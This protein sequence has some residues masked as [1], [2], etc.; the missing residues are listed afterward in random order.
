M[1]NITQININN[2][3]YFFNDIISIRNFYSKLLK[4]N[5]KLY[6]N[7]DIYY[8]RYVAMRNI[9]DY[10]NIHSVNPLYFLSLVK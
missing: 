6:K 3:T 8:I 2:L 5:K 7:I 9:S 4:I 1:G 10:E